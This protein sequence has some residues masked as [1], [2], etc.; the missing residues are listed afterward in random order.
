MFISIKKSHAHS[1]IDTSE[2]LYLLACSV[3]PYAYSHRRCVIYMTACKTTEWLLRVGI[4]QNQRTSTYG[5]IRC[6]YFGVS[7]RILPIKRE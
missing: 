6:I 5:V 7:G 2:K 4:I 3:D 1:K